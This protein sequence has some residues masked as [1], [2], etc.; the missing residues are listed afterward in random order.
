MAVAMS[1]PMNYDQPMQS[2]ICLLREIRQKA[3]W[4]YNE[5]THGGYGMFHLA[6]FPNHELY[7]RFPRYIPLNEYPSY[8]L[9]IPDEQEER[10]SVR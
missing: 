1:C 2:V 9:S 8:V 3:A 10:V 5:N 4:E 6:Y 7:T